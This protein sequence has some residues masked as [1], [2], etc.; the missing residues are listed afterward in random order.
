MS[1]PAHLAVG[2]AP[3]GMVL[4]PAGRTAYVAN[5][6]DGTISVIDLAAQAVTA[7]IAVPGGT[8][9]FSLAMAP[10]GRFLYISG[11]DIPGGVQV[12]DTAT[13]AIAG[14]RFTGPAIAGGSIAVSPDGVRGYVDDRGMGG[15]RILHLDTGVAVDEWLMSE[16]AESVAAAMSPD[17]RFLYSVGNDCIAA[18]IDTR[19]PTAPDSPDFGLPSASAQVASV[20]ITCD[21]T[22][23]KFFR[24]DN[25]AVVVNGQGNLTDA[26][27]L[28]WV[29]ASTHALIGRDVEVGVPASEVIT[30]IAIA[31]HRDEAYL[32]HRD[33]AAR[34]RG[35][36]AVVPLDRLRPPG[37]DR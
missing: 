34:T 30:G 4:D 35:S 9:G 22:D 23:V 37:R 8:V 24:T 31:P 6:G 36:V 11:W 3:L 14:V 19:K 29:D 17:G 10:D 33:R 7:T 5:W 26:S 28:S 12:I 25:L 21:P 27:T 2:P 20:V 13:H 15:F 32:L 1:V 18:V 16:S